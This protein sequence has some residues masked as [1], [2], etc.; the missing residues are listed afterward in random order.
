MAFQ[1]AQADF[2][3]N[4]ACHVSQIAVLSLYFIFCVCEIYSSN[5]KK[6][7]VRMSS[8]KTVQN[9]TLYFRF[10]RINL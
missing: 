8:A 7:S 5:L 10:L 2:I 9:Q 3:P 4:W 1:R 6:E